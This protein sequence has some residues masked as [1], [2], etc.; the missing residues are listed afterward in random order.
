[1]HN[2][3]LSSVAARSVCRLYRHGNLGIKRTTNL[4][5]SY[6]YMDFRRSFRS[7]AALRALKTCETDVENDD[8]G[9]NLVLY[10]YPSFSA[11]LA[12]LFAR[13]YHSLRRLP[14]TVL[15]FSSAE[16][17]RVED[18]K[19]QGLKKCYLLGFIGPGGFAVELSRFIPEVIAFD[20]RK[21]TAKRVL[22]LEGCP[23]NLQLRVDVSKSSARAVYEYFSGKLT[24]GVSLT[25]LNEQEESRVLRIFN[26]IEDDDLRLRNQP[27]IQPF[28]IGLRQL[29]L[30]L[31]S[32]TNP[33]LFD[34]LVE[35]DPAELISRGESHVS[36]RLDEARKLLGAEFK[37]KLGRGFYGECLCIRADGHAHLSHE[38]GDE[39]SKRSAA[40]GLRPIGAVVFMKR[41]LRGNLKMCLRSASGD[42][43]TAEIAKTY[44]GGGRPGS[45]SFIIR[46]DE[47]GQWALPS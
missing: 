25:L 18:L 30:N 35:M 5:L 12:A 1:M 23:G 42:A 40:A 36:S 24:E 20:H 32:I 11:A 34:Q 26:F 44:G 22:E 28:K 8:D 19:I 7:D 31:N 17:L 43:D 13:R 41:G 6:L 10:K 37:I 46:M 47:Y 14:A 45:S 16:P 4:S 33:H 38:I 39:L 21:V 15:P 2:S 27:D 9:F 3:L 29:Q